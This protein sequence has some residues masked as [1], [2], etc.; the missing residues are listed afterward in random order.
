LFGPAVFDSQP[1]HN[2]SITTL[3]RAADGVWTLES[4]G[5][6]PHLRA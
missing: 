4:A 3:T 1:L 5:A 6:T 2:T